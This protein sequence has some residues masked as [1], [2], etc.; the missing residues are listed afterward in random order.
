MTQSINTTKKTIHK[1]SLRKRMLQGASIALLFISFYL[2]KADEPDPNWP[3][4][5]I[6][7][8]LLVVPIAGAMGGALYYY[9]DYLRYQGGWKKALAFLLSLIGYLIALW[10]GI[11]AG[12]DGTYWN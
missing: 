10:L 2:Y 1:A 7:R 4:L 3:S 9:L 11:V 8:P 6:A 5:W 12:L